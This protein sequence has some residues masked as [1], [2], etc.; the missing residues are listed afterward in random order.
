MFNAAKRQAKAVVL[1]GAHPDDVEI[2]MAG[3]DSI[4]H[5]IEHEACL[6]C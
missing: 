4:V 1:F 5:S 6:V 2:G 3:N